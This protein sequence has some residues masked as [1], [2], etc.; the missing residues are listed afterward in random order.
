MLRRLE[1]P[2]GT[3]S[4]ACALVRVLG[5]IV[6]ALVCW[7]DGRL[8]DSALLWGGAV[9]LKLVGYYDPGSVAHPR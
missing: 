9:A 3:F 8:A 5:A 2:H 6:E 4:L 7:R 1:A